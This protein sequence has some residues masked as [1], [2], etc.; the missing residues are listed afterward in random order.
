MRYKGQVE[1]EL[2]ALG[3]AHLIIARPGFIMDGDRGPPSGSCKHCLIRAM[4]MP[5]LNCD[6]LGRAMARA[7][8]RPEGPVIVLEN[9]DLLALGS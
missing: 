5:A 6:V 8:L 1:D 7:A 2:K 4:C 3:F 9:A